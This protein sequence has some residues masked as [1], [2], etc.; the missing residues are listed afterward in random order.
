MRQLKAEALVIGGGAAGAYAAL[1]LQRQGVAPLVVSKGFVGKSGASIFAGNLVISGRI[2]GNTEDNARDTAEFLIKYHNQFLIDQEY[3]K[4]CGQWIAE[5]YYPEL[6]EAGLYFRRDDEGNLVTSPGRIRSIAANVQGNSGV[7]FM[8]LRRKQLLKAGVPML[9]EAAVTALVQNESG[10]VCG[11]VVLDIATGEIFSVLAKAVVLATGYA[12]RLHWRSTG[13]REMSADGIALAYR[14]GAELVNLEMQ[15]WH[16]ND[17]RHPENWQRMQVYPNPMLGSW[18]SARNV[19]SAG[20]VF[21]NQQEDDP[22]AFGPYTVQLKHLVKQVR[23]GKAR[24]D[25]GYFSGF[26]HV[27]PAEVDAYTSYA[28]LF[29]Q[30]GLDVGSQL[31][32]TAVSAHYR[33]GGILVDPQ[34]MAST[35]PGLYVAGGVGGHSNGLI[36]LVTYDGKVAADSVAGRVK[37]RAYPAIPQSRLDDERR[38][39]EEL[40]R[41]LDARG[42]PPVRIKKTI[43]ELMW[44]YMGVEKN[45]AGMARALEMLDKI[46]AES[47]HAMGLKSLGRS[48]NQGWLDAIDV[49]N[50]VDACSLMVHSTLN[51]KE[52]RGP[53]I[54]TDYPD[55]DNENWLVQNILVPTGQGKFTF[56]TRPYDLPYYRPDFAR[57]DNLSVAW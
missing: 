30:L 23:A 53:L 56:R 25:G 7:P 43:R 42:I 3:A 46:R 34:T 14:V 5:V 36:A 48:F 21:F 45:A 19:N 22:M 41:P 50:M 27:D 15:W 40:L 17:V 2:L 10:E 13:T 37:D 52:S 6:E 49:M 4:R 31:V 18:K 16:T 24:Y 29:K 39:L 55:M 51:R 35:V 9:E 44:N 12:D 20:E 11:A 32:E 8:D 38:R 1:C 26:D 28:K 33:Q 54:R 47:L 57:R